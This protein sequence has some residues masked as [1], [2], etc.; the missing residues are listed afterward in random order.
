MN[1]GSLTSQIEDM[2]KSLNAGGNKKV[3]EKLDKSGIEKLFDSLSGKGDSYSISPEAQRS[4]FHYQSLSVIQESTFAQFKDE[5]GNELIIEKQSFKLTFEEIWQKTYT[6][7]PKPEP[8]DIEKFDKKLGNYSSD[9]VAEKL[10]DFAKAVYGLFSNE[11]SKYF[12]PSMTDKDKYLEWAKGNISKGFSDAAA[13]FNSFM[14]KDDPYHKIYQMTYDKTMAGLEKAFGKVAE[15]GEVQSQP[16]NSTSAE[17][18][19][20]RYFELNIEQTYVGV[21]LV[22]DKI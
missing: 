11:N 2:F 13:I 10:V 22:E 6:L 9:K 15:E 20:H 3:P 14:P 12:S 8:E 5:N 4:L 21:N 1:T 19:E 17:Y 16:A 18:Y 7:P